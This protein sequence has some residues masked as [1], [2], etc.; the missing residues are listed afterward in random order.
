MEDLFE[1]PG[2]ELGYKILKEPQI[3]YITAPVVLPALCKW[4][5][6]GYYNT[7]IV[8]CLN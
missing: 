2:E 7:H 6:L 3:P 1:D 8:K 5:R 4:G